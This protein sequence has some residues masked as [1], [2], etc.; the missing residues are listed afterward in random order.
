MGGRSID[1]FIETLLSFVAM[2]VKDNLLRRRPKSD[3]FLKRA[4]T[5][6][7]LLRR[8][9]RRERPQLTIRLLRSRRSQLAAEAA[10][11]AVT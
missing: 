11:V 6:K 8:L 2:V 9:E 10:P 4:K 5:L 7:T 3:C 1:V